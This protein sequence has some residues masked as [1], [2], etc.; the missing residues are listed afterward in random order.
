MSGW[1]VGARQAR[2][3]SQRMSAERS[4]AA[5]AADLKEARSAAVVAAAQVRVRTSGDR[6]PLM[7]WCKPGVN[8]V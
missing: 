7:I 2:A 8:Q 3:T 4:L 1:R 6:S 5:A